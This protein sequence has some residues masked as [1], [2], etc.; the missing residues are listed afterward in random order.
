MSGCEFRD[1]CSM[2]KTDLGLSIPDSPSLDWQGQP[3]SGDY[4]KNVC[5]GLTSTQCPVRSLIYNSDAAKRAKADLA[6][7]NERI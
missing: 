5:D 2:Y 6:G 3:L 1:R 7:I 4:R